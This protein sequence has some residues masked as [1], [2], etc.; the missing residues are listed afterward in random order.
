MKT[1]FPA[2]GPLDPGTDFKA[3]GSLQRIIDFDTFL[4]GFRRALEGVLKGPS[5]DPFK[6]PSSSPS[7]TLSETPAE[8]PSETLLKPYWGPGVLP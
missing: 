3:P 1:S 7:E 6:N 8:T 4:N 2:T 5:A